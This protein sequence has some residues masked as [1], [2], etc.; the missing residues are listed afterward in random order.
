MTSTVTE[1]TTEPWPSLPLSA[2]RET[3]ETLHMWTQIVGKVKLALTPF[4]NEWW[5]VAF[6]VT[7]RGLTT[8]P[9][10]SET[11]IFAIDFDFID[12]TLFVRASDGGSAAIPLVPRS[13]AD[14]YT[15]LLGT[16]EAMGIAV[17]FNPMPVEIPDPISCDVDRVHKSYD[18]ACAQRWWRILVQTERILQRYRS[19]FLGK[20]SP[21]NFYWGSFDLSAT[22]FSGRA[23]TPPAGAPQFLQ[24][25]EDQENFACGFWPGNTSL[26]GVTLGEPGF[27]AYAYP[28]PP[29]FK[30]AQV[31]PSAASY[32]PNLGEFLLRYED[33][34]RAP[35]P[36]QAILDFF[37]STYEAAATLAGWDRETL[38]RTPPKGGTR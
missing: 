27:Y 5:N 33:A 6:S 30:E 15:H 8:G 29:G 21:I 12:H 37:Q 9:I 22:R 28:E 18:P 34:R 2:W 26:S 38:E 17:A 13:V 10:P 24:L 1:Q 32:D 36:E 19:P 20:S 4:L 11:G 16:L 23:A 14:V 25:A 31:R 3:Q 7:P 35:A